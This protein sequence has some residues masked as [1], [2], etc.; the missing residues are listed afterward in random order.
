MKLASEGETMA[1]I[2]LVD[3]EEAI[4]E[5][6]ADCL[7]SAGHVVEQ[8]ASGKSALELLEGKTYDLI[9]MDVFMP[10]MDGIELIQRLGQRATYPPVITISGG[11]GIL[12][13]GWSAKLTEVYGVASA[14]TKPI[15]L[16]F[17]LGTVERTVLA[18]E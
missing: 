9:V 5:T 1:Q 10:E 17:F 13:P 6:L 8:A 3:D 2:L 4:R 7:D 12:P 14:L 18:Q 15:D 11:G 16:D